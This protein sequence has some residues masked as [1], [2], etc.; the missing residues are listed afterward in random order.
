[1]RENETAVLKIALTPAAIP[2]KFVNQGRGRLF[3]RAVKLIRQPYA[4]SGL[5]HQRGLD[6]VMAEDFPAQ[7]ASARA[8]WAVDSAP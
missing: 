4:V 8:V 2:D 1:M 6:K 3:P 5:A 7:G